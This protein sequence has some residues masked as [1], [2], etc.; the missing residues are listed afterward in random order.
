MLDSKIRFLRQEF[1]RNIENLTILGR[2]VSSGT[3][4]AKSK[5]MIP[6]APLKESAKKGSRM[7][8]K[9][10]GQILLERC[11]ITETELELALGR[12]RVEKGKYLGQILLEMGVPQDEI[13][14]ALDS[15][16]IRKRIGQILVDSGVINPQQLEQALEKQKS[17][18]K[19]GV[20]KP[21]ATLLVELGYISETGYL[22]ALAKFFTM[23]ITYLKEFLPTSRLQRVVGE[24]YAQKNK[25]IVIENNSLVLKIALAE[26]TFQIMEELKKGLPAGK[27]VEFH[28]ASLSE[29]KACLRKFEPLM[30]TR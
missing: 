8:G 18:R 19:E 10:L 29:I 23:P 9:S 30:R 24:R 6:A 3:E 2:K 16:Y 17:L 11:I 25:V 14:K 15:F 12:Q 27:R 13:N 20:R 1:F 22:R 5:R 4:I 7:E 21:L 28:L 26:P